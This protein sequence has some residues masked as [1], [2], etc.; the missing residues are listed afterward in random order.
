MKKNSTKRLIF[1]AI[2]ASVAAVLMFLEFPL[3]FAPGFYEMDFS[4]V[5]V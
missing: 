3:W 4:E 5:P 2:L 1:A